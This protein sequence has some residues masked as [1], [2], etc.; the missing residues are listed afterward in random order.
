[1]KTHIFVY[2]TLQPGQSRWRIVEPFAVGSHTAIRAV[3]QGQLFDTGYGWPAAVFSPGV[4]YPVPGVV[5]AIRPESIHEALT[6]LDAVEGVGSGLFRRITIKVERRPCWTYHWPGSTTEF[7]RIT[8]WPRGQ[9][10]DAN[11]HMDASEM[12]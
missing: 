7:R 1:M 11:Q 9:S 2:G 12:L 5:I 4:S 10:D 6:M 3:A 8:R